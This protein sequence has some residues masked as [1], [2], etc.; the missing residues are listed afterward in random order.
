MGIRRLHRNPELIELFFSVRMPALSTPQ[1]DAFGRWLKGDANKKIMPGW[2]FFSQVLWA[3]VLL[4]VFLVYIHGRDRL[5]LP[6]SFGRVP[7]EA[8][9]LGAVG[10][11]LASLGGVTYYNHGRWQWQFNYWHPVK[12]LMGA[13]SGAV[14]SVLVI[15]LVRTATGGDKFTV[16][17]TALDAAAFVFGYGEAAFR[18]LIAAVTTIFLKP[19]S[20]SEPSKQQPGGGG[21]GT[22]GVS[23][24]G[25]AAAVAGVAEGAG[26]AAAVAGPGGAVVVEGAGAEGAVEAAGAEG[27]VEGAGAEG[28]VEGPGAEGAVEGAGAEGAVEGPGAHGAV[29]GADEAGNGENAS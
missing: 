3:G 5:D 19:G 21:A 13:A 27:A 16:D 1:R 2:V 9:W 25:E 7:V 15:V 24:A 11:L 17:A 12:P 23:G 14:A 6:H 26:G 8:P 20:N 18:Q 10:G 29:E 4:V 28:A 22:T